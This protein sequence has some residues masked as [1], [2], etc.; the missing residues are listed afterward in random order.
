MK[1][2]LVRAFQDGFVTKNGNLGRCKIAEVWKEIIDQNTLSGKF[3]RD[4]KSYLK[5]FL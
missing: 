1:G 2:F 5:C 4:S 3:G